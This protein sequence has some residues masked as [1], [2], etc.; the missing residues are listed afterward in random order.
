MSMGENVFNRILSS[1]RKNLA[2]RKAAISNYKDKL[3]YY[4]HYDS[5]TRLPNKTTLMEKISDISF[6][7][8]KNN[9]IVIVVNIDHFKLIN[10]SMGQSFANEL[11]KAV[12]DRLNNI[13]GFGNVYKLDGDEFAAIHRLPAS[14]GLIKFLDYTHD[15][16]RKPFI[17]GN[18]KL[19]LNMSMGV[20][21][22]P[23]GE[24]GPRDILN[25]AEIA[26]S[27]AKKRGRNRYLVYEDQMSESVMERMLIERLLH[28]AL[29]KSEFELYYQPQMVMESGRISGFEALI[30]WN[31][32]ELGFVQ[33]NRFIEIA[34]ETHLIVPI[35]EWV[36]RTACEFIKKL[37][38]QGYNDLT[39]SVNVSIVQLL[40]EE[41]V[42]TV[43]NVLKENGLDHKY[44]VLE[45][46]E[47]I[48]V[49][50]YE[51][52]REKLQFLKNQGIK[53]AMDDFGKGYSS[54]GGLSQLPINTLKIDKI[55][56]DSLLQDLP[57]Q[58]ITDMIIQIG[59]KMGLE[60]LAEGVETKD[61]VEYLKKY[62][63]LKA[64]GYYFSRP[65]PARNAEELIKSIHKNGSF[66]LNY[67]IA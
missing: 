29:E 4:I 16:L 19:H 60:V 26:L 11:I 54:L 27:E 64:Q 65:I 3:D 44:L 48:L 49:K 51:S 43:K 45:I 23:I 66:Q 56:M 25:C 46:T 12:A 57:K 62:G 8:L 50:S 47:T 38:I 7:Q 63:S 22:C 55:F 21:S 52:I 17:I 53:I 36:L 30:R 35:G 15:T 31:S 33:P 13:F 14:F 20:V 67:G 6:K 61:Q 39:I 1:I 32:P 5:L 18:S 59:N 2:V 37:H 28:Q 41:F 40:Q 10:D 42:D 58:I 9:I 24:E 34:E